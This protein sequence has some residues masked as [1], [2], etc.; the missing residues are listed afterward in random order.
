MAT[1]TA[2]PRLSFAQKLLITVVLA[3]L[4]LGAAAWIG[5]R[6]IERH[7]AGLLGPRAQVADV[8]LGFDAVVLTDVRISGPEGC[9]LYT[10]QRNSSGIRCARSSVTASRS[11]L[12]SNWPEQASTP[13]SLSAVDACLNCTR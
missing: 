7:I 9:L 3:V 1:A 4:L 13:A 8:R 2:K 10:S 5:M 12:A 11:R 6:V